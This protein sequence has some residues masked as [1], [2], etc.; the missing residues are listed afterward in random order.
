MLIHKIAI[1]SCKTNGVLK[2]RRL[3]KRLES[4]LMKLRNKKGAGIEYKII[5]K[6]N[7][8]YL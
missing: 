4:C 7:I 2:N 6:R 5:P 8:L 3:E 1:F